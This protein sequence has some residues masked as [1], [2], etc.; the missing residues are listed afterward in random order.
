MK[1]EI[2]NM[3]TDMIIYIVLSIMV[4]AIFRAYRYDERHTDEYLDI[5]S[6]I[7][8]V[9]WPV[10]IFCTLLVLSIQKLSL[11]FLII[12]NKLRIKLW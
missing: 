5:A 11:L 6:M 12:K 4:G 8:G 1:E 3:I 7:F 2:L 9:L 10:S